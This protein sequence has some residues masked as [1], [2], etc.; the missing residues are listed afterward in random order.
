M[1]MGES[2]ENA[3][4]GALKAVGSGWGSVQ[5]GGT[6]GR[7]VT[8]PAS[9]AGGVVLQGADIATKALTDPDYPQIGNPLKQMTKSVVDAAGSKVNDVKTKVDNAGTNLLENINNLPGDV[10]R[11]YNLGKAINENDVETVSNM[12]NISKDDAGKY[13]DDQKQMVEYFI[14]TGRV[15]RKEL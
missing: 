10:K 1:G 2:K 15:F 12:L 13:I 6:L 8:N 5:D 3:E 14:K 4:K 7:F 11:G 9:L